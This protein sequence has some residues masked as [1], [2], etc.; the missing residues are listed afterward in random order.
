MIALTFGILLFYD[1]STI[2]Q[3]ILCTG[4]ILVAILEFYMS[5]KS[6]KVSF[7]NE[8]IY[9]SGIRT[10]KQVPIENIL[11][12][13]PGIFPIRFFYG[14][15]YAVTVKYI[16]GGVQKKISF[17]SKRVPGVV[18]TRD[19]IPFLDMLKDLVREKKYRRGMAILC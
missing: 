11:E 10:K 16:D 13:M 14:T 6:W 17:F 5:I 2:G 18:G 19:N 8:F 9:I 15:V 7:D 1:F 4:V 3:C 12:I